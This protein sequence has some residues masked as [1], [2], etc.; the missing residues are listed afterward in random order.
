VGFRLCANKINQVSVT[1][2]TAFCNALLPAAITR[3]VESVRLV[4]PQHC[5]TRAELVITHTMT[6]RLT[7]IRSRLS[8][9]IC[10]PFCCQRTLNPIP[11]ERLTFREAR[12]VGLIWQRC[13]ASPSSP[14]FL[15]P[16]ENNLGLLAIQRQGSG[17]IERLR[18]LERSEGYN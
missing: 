8:A 13:A 2:H 7:V 17:W 12:L 1:F 10:Q 6:S 5:S 14:A 18:S 4:I 3:L 9:W 16:L 11:S 15:V